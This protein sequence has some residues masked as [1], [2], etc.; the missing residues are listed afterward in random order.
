MDV[1]RKTVGDWSGRQ[2]LL[3]NWMERSLGRPAIWSMLNTKALAYTQAAQ[4]TSICQADFRYSTTPTATDPELDDQFRINSVVYRVTLAARGGIPNVEILNL[5]QS[6]NTAA[7][8]V[9]M[10]ER[11]TLSNILLSRILNKL[12]DDKA[13]AGRQAERTAPVAPTPIQPQSRPRNVVSALAETFG[14]YNNEL[15]A[16]MRRQGAGD[17]VDAERARR[18]AL[19]PKERAAED[20]WNLGPRKGE[21]MCREEHG[22]TRCKTGR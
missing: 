8:A 14:Q 20:A 6:I 11:I 13:V 17:I 10:G 12:R 1:F 16:E 22:V 18:A 4:P 15:E 5:P 21:T 9:W 3:V 19:T 7:D 2:V